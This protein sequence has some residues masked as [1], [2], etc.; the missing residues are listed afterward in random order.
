[1]PLA[2]VQKACGAATT[3]LDANATMWNFFRPLWLPQT[4]AS[5]EFGPG[6]VAASPPGATGFAAGGAA[7]SPPGAGRCAAGAASAPM[8]TNG[9]FSPFVSGVAPLPGNAV[10]PSSAY[11]S[12]FPHGPQ[13]MSSQVQM[14]YSLPGSLAASTSSASGASFAGQSSASGPSALQHPLLSA[15]P[16]MV[17]AGGGVSARQESLWPTAPVPAAYQPGLY[18]TEALMQDSVVRTPVQST[19]PSSSAVAPPPYTTQG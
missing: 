9:V 4:V 2:S 6:A 15:G 3:V 18:P 14:G 5:P 10:P 8:P 11:T 7:F 12:A 16:G 13:S 1:M 19:A 17:S